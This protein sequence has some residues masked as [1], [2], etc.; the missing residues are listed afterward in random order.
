MRG[1]TED[2]E[3]RE[4]KKDRERVVQKNWNRVRVQNR[5]CT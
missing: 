2:N 4:R 1:T 3:K 5:V